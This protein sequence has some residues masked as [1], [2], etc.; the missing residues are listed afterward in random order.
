MENQHFPKERKNCS[1]TVGKCSA[2]NTF[3]C[4][5]AEEEGEKEVFERIFGCGLRMVV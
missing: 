2:A 5:F 1:G 4:I 3:V